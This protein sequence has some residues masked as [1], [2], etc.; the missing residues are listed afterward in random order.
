MRMEFS[1]PIP[2]HESPDRRL[3]LGRFVPA[4]VNRV[5]PVARVKGT[6]HVLFFGVLTAGIFPLFQL[7]KRLNETFLL[8]AQQLELAAE[9]VVC[10]SDPQEALEMT[11]ASG[12]VGKDTGFQTLTDILILGSLVALIGALNQSGWTIRSYT[13]LLFQSPS[14]QPVWGLWWF[15]LVCMSYLMLH[16]RIN[17]HIS[18]LQDFALAFNTITHER[19]PPVY[20]PR[21][22]WGLRVMT[23]IL[24]GSMIV[25]VGGLWVIPMFLAW[26]A[27]QTFVLDIDTR[28]R[29]DLSDR[30]QQL[31][32]IIPVVRRPGVCQNPGCDQPLL[33][34][35]RFCPRCGRPVGVG[36]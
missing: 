35:T 20:L 24:S 17:R 28:F 4:A 8:Q 3:L 9:L 36:A 11:R 30:L 13:H 25:L 19:V 10:H 15:G 26:G 34:E 18:R 27:F 21:P 2:S 16:A 5:P 29:S 14:D 33:P 7:R 1:P 23:V 6:L 31:S 22:T 32:G 12:A